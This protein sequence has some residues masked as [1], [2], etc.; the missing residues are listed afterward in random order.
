MNI[1]NNLEEILEDFAVLGMKNNEEWQI[2]QKNQNYFEKLLDNL[3]VYVL[4]IYYKA[5][6]KASEP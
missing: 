3:V 4:Q 1:S 2:F 6:T 5:I